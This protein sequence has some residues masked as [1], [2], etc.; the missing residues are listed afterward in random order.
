MDVDQAAERLKVSEATT[1]RRIRAGVLE[2]GVS[3]GRTVVSRSSVESYLARVAAGVVPRD[4]RHRRGPDRPP[5]SWADRYPDDVY[6]Q[7]REKTSP[8]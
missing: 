8:R 2:G 6:L 1:Y 7:T 3:H 4:L 5:T